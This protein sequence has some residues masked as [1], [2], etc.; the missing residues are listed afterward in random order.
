MFK[1]RFEFERRNSGT[2]R[3]LDRTKF[4]TRS[5]FG[6]SK[7]T[8]VVEKSSLF[9][10]SFRNFLTKFR[11]RDQI[12]F[13]S[14]VF[15]EQTENSLDFT[16]NDESQLSQSIEIVTPVVS[17]LEN[18]SS[19]ESTN[20]NE[21][22]A[23]KPAVVDLSNDDPPVLIEKR[24]KSSTY[25][26][27]ENQKEKFRSPEPLPSLC[28]DQSVISSMDTP[29]I[30]SMLTN[31]QL[32][33]SSSSNSS[34]SDENWMTIDNTTQTNEQSSDDD[35]PEESSIAK[36]L[37]RS[38]R[39]STSARK[40]LAN[41]A[42][43]QRAIP[44]NEDLSSTVTLIP[45]AEHCQET[46]E[47]TTT[48][49]KHPIKSILKRLSPGKVRPQHNRRV[50]F[51]DHVKVLLFTSPSRRE[52]KNFIQQRKRVQIRDELRNSSILTR[53]SGPLLSQTRPSKL[54][55]LNETQQSQVN[56]REKVVRSIV[57]LFFL[58]RWSS[59]IFLVQSRN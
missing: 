43:K 16:A 40:S 54:F 13:P 11:D 21:I 41:G 49:S 1:V 29:T 22:P 12:F 52:N 34:N 57:S 14:I 9:F 6:S 32:D 26:L 19:T 56:S 7:K 36:K 47:T 17:R 38:A 48:S 8:K 59:E 15:D 33:T 27:T 50:V 42:R 23:N 45:S 3:L 25:S 55:Y 39:P 18:R 20:S 28:D 37:R 46:R 44:S 51:H 53:R 30:E 58:C 5:L 35:V 4:S 10:F 24:T 2:K 31:Y